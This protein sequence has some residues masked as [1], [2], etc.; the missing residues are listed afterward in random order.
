MPLPQFNPA[1]TRIDNLPD[2]RYRESLQEAREAYYLTLD[3]SPSCSSSGIL[4]FF[5]LLPFLLP[6]APLPRVLALGPYTSGTSHPL[7]AALAERIEEVE[8]LLA[9]AAAGLTNGGTSALAGTPGP[10]SLAGTPR[11]P[12]PQHL[13]TSTPARSLFEHN[14][15]LREEARPSPE[16]LDAQMRQLTSELGRT[17]STLARCCS[18]T[19]TIITTSTTVTTIDTITTTHTS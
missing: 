15:S 13:Q 11:R 14:A 2:P 19:Y 16:R 18:S 12:L 5:F 7:D 6:P 8:Q 10:A 3:R 9:G 17:T 1:A 4:H